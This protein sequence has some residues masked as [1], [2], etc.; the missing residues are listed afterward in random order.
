MFK[1]KKFLNKQK[2]PLYSYPSSANANSGSVYLNCKSISLIFQQVGGQGGC[3]WLPQL[4]EII[5]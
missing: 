3:L 2:T 4:A 5:Q 1:V